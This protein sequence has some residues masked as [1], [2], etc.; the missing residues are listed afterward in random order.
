MILECVVLDHRKC[1]GVWWNVLVDARWFCTQQANSC[2]FSWWTFICAHSLDSL[3]N[4][5]FFFFERECER[6]QV[7]EGGGAEEEGKNPKQAPR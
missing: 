4:F 3:L 1:T 2:Q 7:G 5:F 6:V